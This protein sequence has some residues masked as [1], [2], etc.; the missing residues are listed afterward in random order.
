MNSFYKLFI[1]IL[2]LFSF[3]LNYGQT[4]TIYVNENLELISEE[5]FNKSEVSFNYL[6][7]QFT[8]DTLIVKTKAKR[9]NRGQL[10]DR[11]YNRI[12]DNINFIS[13]DKKISEKDI[14]IINYYPG[15]DECNNNSGNDFLKSKYANYTKKV[16]KI[17]NVKQ[18]YF[19]KEIG[20]ISRYGKKLK[21]YEDPHSIFEKLFF[22]IHYPCGSYLIIFPDKTYVSYFGEYNLDDIFDELQFKKR[23]DKKNLKN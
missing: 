10:T 7:S 1:L 18:F 22:K 12:K 5:E 19:Y 14:I 23:L 4:K 6:Y 3:N 17:T 11:I 16:N 13:S 9:D 20:N 21:W 2:I 8:T 15:L